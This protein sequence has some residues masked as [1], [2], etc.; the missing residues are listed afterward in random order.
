MKELKEN[1]IENSTLKARLLLS[2]VL[3]VKK[4]FLISHDLDEICEKSLNENKEYINRLINYEPIQ[5]II[6]KQEFYGIE[7]TVNK[8]VLIPQPDTEILVE[9]VI[10]LC[11][12]RIWQI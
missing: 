3:N 5:Y 2:F 8:N 10:S 6:G 7:L 1:N 9:E 11:N 4:E 12:E